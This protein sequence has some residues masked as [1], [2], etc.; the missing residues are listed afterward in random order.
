M[1]RVLRVSHT[2]FLSFA[3]WEGGGGAEALKNEMWRFHL[4]QYGVADGYTGSP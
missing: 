4:Q 2:K 3:P 1:K